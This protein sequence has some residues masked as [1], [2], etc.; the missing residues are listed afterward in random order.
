M[1]ISKIPSMDIDNIDNQLSIST[2][3]IVDVDDINIV[4]INK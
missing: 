1:L 2:I 4:D 3:P